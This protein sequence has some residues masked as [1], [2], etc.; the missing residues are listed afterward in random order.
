MT[1]KGRVT[2]RDVAVASGHAVSTVSNALAGK[3]YVKEETR[4]HVRE[5]AMRLGYRPSALAQS[6]R[7]RRSSTIGVLVSDVS[8]PALTEFIRGI[9]DVAVREGCT[10]LLGNTDEILE[11]QIGQMRT[12][13][14]RQVDGMVF[15]SQ[16][17]D[18]PEVRDLLDGT[19]PFVLIQRR[20]RRFEDDYVGSDNAQGM[21]MSV[22]YLH[23]L[24]HRRI[25][26]ITGPGASS[27]AM[28]RLD[29][30]RQVAADLGCDGDA[31]LVFRGDYTVGAGYNAMHYFVRLGYP[32][33]A[34]I[35]SNDICALGVQDASIELGLNIPRDLSLMGSDDILLAGLRQINLTTLHLPKRRM[36]VAAA[37]LLLERIRGKQDDR[38]AEIIVESRLVER[39]SCSKPQN[40]MASISAR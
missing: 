13:L 6:L 36:G 20:S 12:L 27:T 19:T 26:L 21:E 28:E 35:A 11:K 2:I 34:I 8:N 17:S 15:I 22:R 32:P 31:E 9:D 25:G 40:P 23:D 39:G 7:M 24:G 18:E 5:V 30:F 14:D 10:I 1:N 38:P 3:H 37:E 4:R 33:T 29:A 16:H